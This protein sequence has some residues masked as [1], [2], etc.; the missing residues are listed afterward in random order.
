[1]S[2]DDLTK[3]Q[4]TIINTAK[5]NKNATNKEIAEKA[6]ASPSY[7]SQV[8]NEHGDPR[9]KSGDLLKWVIIAVIVIGILALIGEGG[10]GGEEAA[11]LLAAI[12]DSIS[13]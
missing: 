4:E 13:F 8:L 3:K 9:E 12:W 11:M 1:M 2:D 5:R 7:V 10:E 6:D